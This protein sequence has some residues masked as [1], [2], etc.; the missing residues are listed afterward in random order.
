METIK[1]I[2]ESIGGLILL[3]AMSSVAAAYAQDNTDKWPALPL[4]D[5]TTND[6]A[7]PTATVVNPPEG[8]LG[9]SI[10]SEHVPGRLVITLEGDT[11]Y[12]SGDYVKGE[13]GMRM[14]IRGN[15]TGANLAQHPY[16]LKLSKKADLLNLGKSYKSKDCAVP[17]AP[18]SSKVASS[19]AWCTMANA[20]I[21]LT[22]RL[23][24]CSPT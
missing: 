19:T 15:T 17:T 24:T 11:L 1:K 16:K 22:N 12:D 6:G 3:M 18:P 23:M 14:K 8:C 10:V 13:S 2:R 4:L 20:P 21:H 9:Q 7:E 5:I